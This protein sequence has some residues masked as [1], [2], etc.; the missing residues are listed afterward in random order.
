[1]TLQYSELSPEETE[2]ATK[3]I[4][5]MDTPFDLSASKI[6]LMSTPLLFLKNSFLIICENYQTVPFQSHFFLCDVNKEYRPLSYTSNPYADNLL[7]QME[8]DITEDAVEQYLFFYFK[9]LQTQFGRLTPIKHVDDIQWKD[10]L[11]LVSRQSLE[12][13]I[14]SYPKITETN[15]GFVVKMSCLYQSALVEVELV[16]CRDGQVEIQ[17][18]TVL[19]DDLPTINFS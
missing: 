10:D 11:P 9:L 15:D 18:I 3:Q 5:Q 7:G 2:I 13:E 12:K 14:Q 16:L 1:M 17:T 4:N 6:K 8:L 19:I